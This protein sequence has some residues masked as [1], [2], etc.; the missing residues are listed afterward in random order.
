MTPFKG[1]PESFT[2]GILLPEKFFNEVLPLIDSLDEL[3]IC[4]Q[5]FRLHGQRVG[6]DPYLTAE[7]FLE[8]DATIT[9]EGVRGAL[10]RAGEQGIL[11]M[12]VNQGRNLYFLNTPRARA[13]KLAV[14]KGTWKPDAAFAPV[15]Q[16]SRPNV[17]ELYE[18]NI[19]PLTP[20]LS[21]MLEEAEDDYPAEWLEEAIKL[22]VKKNVRNWN[23]VEAI[24]RSWKEKGRNETDRRN[25]QENPRRYIEGDLADYIKH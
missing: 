18:K 11:V 25:D 13:I 4:L 5:F 24:L 8:E 23:Y 16:T 12:V 10:A 20:I 15:L 14:G 19:G 22:A 2:G 1:F 7:D 6:T 21:Q 17:F 9:I 3:K